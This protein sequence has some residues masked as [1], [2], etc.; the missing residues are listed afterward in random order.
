M[1]SRM[2]TPKQVSEY[3]GLSE[4]TLANRRYMRRQPAF[5][6]VGSSIRYDSQ[7]IKTWWQSCRQEP[8]R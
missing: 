2:W 7:E 8:T 1:A 5:Y 6:K 4:E 3:T